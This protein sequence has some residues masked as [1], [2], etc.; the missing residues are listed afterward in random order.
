MLEL[1]NHFTGTYAKNLLADWS[2]ISDFIRQKTTWVKDTVRGETEFHP[3]KFPTLND[4]QI[5]DAL[6][7]PF[8]HFFKAHLRAHAQISKVEA[9]LSITKED[10]FKDAEQPIEAPFGLPQPFLNKM[11]F[12]TFKEL[13]NKLDALTKAHYAQEELNIQD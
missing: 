8:Q 2:V 4:Q 6:N 3:L 9:A 12:S 11:E 7:G 10:L 13:R 5:N 1:K